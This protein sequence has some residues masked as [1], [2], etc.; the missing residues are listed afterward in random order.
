MEYVVIRPPI[1]SVTHPETILAHYVV[2]RTRIREVI[3]AYYDGK[4]IVKDE[5][6]PLGVFKVIVGKR[7]AR[8][9]VEAAQLAR[10]KNPSNNNVSNLEWCDNSY[11]VKYSN[12][13]KKL[14][15]LR[16]DKLEITNIETNET[17]IANS[18]REAA[19]IINGTDTGIIYAINNNTLYKRKYK[20]KIISYGCK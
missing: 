12:I 8:T 7:K 19:D 9:F 20:I 6:P 14:R 1:K 15:E 2:T 5:Y 4:F 18:K 3:N 10:Y 13:P 17:I 16:G 11:N